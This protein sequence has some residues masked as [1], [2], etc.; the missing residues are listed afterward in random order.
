MMGLGQLSHQWRDNFMIAVGLVK[1]FHAKQVAAS[2]AFQPRLVTSKVGGEFIH[3]AISPLSSCNLLADVLTNAPVKLNHRHIHRLIGAVTGG[4][5]E[6]QHF[7]KL[8][9]SG[10]S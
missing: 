3:H 8:R 6:A 1:L 9:Q 10:S 4:L 5:D 7:L 2:E